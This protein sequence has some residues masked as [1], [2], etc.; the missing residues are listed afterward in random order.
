MWRFKKWPNFTP[1]ALLSFQYCHFWRN[2]NDK[3]RR[4][5]KMNKIIFSPHFEENFQ[6]QNSI[7][8]EILKLQKLGYWRNN[9]CKFATLPVSLESI[10]NHH[11]PITDPQKEKV[12]DFEGYWK[13][14][15]VKMWAGMLQIYIFC[16]FPVFIKK[17]G[18]ITEVSKNKTKKIQDKRNKFQIIKLGSIFQN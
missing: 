6:T 18:S 16:L 13:Y 9:L 17:A 4:R 5:K 15:F 8:F 2:R 14:K 10:Y 11:N 7:V 1:K 3:Y 12:W